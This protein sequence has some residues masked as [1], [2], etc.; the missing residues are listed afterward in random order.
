MLLAGC[1]ASGGAGSAEPERTE[2][3]ADDAI[4]GVETLGFVD[5]DGSKIEAIAVR[6][7]VDLTGADV[8]ADDFAITDYGLTL[9]ENDLNYGENPGAALRAYVNDAPA[10]SPE[11]GSGTGQ[12][13]IIETDTAFQVSRFAR[14]YEVTMAAGV[15]QT[16]TLT[17][18][19][20]IITPSTA[21]VCNYEEV[22]YT[23]YDPNTGEARPPERR[24][25][26][27]ITT[28]RKREHSR[29][30]GLAA[31]NCIRLRAGRRS[32]RRVALTRPTGNTGIL[33][34]PTRSTSRRIMTR[35]SLTRWFY[36]FTTPGP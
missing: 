31:T 9:T 17:T 8:S 11:G 30:P 20:N 21:E 1:G 29:L 34:C 14:S 23:G 24:G 26:Q 7:G 32:M 2:I 4:E 35:R 16:G 22:T 18:D 27:S 15:T 12:Y 33:I 10:I 25:P 36:T 3:S 19:A 13:V 6:Y 5:I 28:T